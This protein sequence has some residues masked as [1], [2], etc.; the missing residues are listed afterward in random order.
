[1]TVLVSGGGGVRSLKVVVSAMDNTEE[2]SVEY[3]TFMFE[4]QQHAWRNI[5]LAWQKMG[6]LW[7]CLD[8]SVK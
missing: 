8:P 3:M 6:R 5:F 7:L 2:V 1:M 4:I